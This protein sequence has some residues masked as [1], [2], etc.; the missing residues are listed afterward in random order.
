ML[1]NVLLFFAMV[2]RY[3]FHCKYVL[4]GG[5]IWVGGV[6]GHPRTIATEP[7]FQIFFLPSYLVLSNSITFV[8]YSYFIFVVYPMSN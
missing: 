3:T 1:S 6:S 2:Q 7:I 5:V 4:F 8:F